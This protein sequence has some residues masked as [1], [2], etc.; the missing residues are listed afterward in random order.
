MTDRTVP[1]AVGRGGDANGKRGHAWWLRELSRL[2]LPGVATSRM[3]AG[4][5]DCRNATPKSI[6]SSPIPILMADGGRLDELTDR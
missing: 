2:P 1:V 4:G 6:L 3:A 5:R